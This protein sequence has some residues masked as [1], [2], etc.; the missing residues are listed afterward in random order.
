M[1]PIRRFPTCSCRPNLFPMSA[2]CLQR[3]AGNPTK[4]LP[5]GPRTWSPWKA[6][7][8]AT[9][10]SRRTARGLSGAGTT[11]AIPVSIID[12]RP[13]SNTVGSVLDP[14]IS[15]R[16]TVRIPPGTTARVVFSTIVAPTREQVMELADKYR[17][18]DN[19]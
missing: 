3:A 9:C 7:R 8:S 14:V 2:R 4:K 6:K 5:F 18:A 12:G 19:L 15:L 13:L 10:N 17:G 16:R 11:C 1:W